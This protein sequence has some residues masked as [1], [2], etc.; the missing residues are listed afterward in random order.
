MLIKV[1]GPATSP[2]SFESA[3]VVSAKFL[4]GKGRSFRFPL[5]FSNNDLKHDTAAVQRGSVILGVRVVPLP[6]A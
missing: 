4:A 5:I 1:S 6:H 2:G 3:M